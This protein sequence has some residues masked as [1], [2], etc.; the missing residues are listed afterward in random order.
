MKKHKFNIFP[1]A[2]PDDYAKILKDIKANGYDAS[3]PITTYQGDILDGWNRQ[4]ACN[5]LG[6]APIYSEFAGSDTEAV[7]FMARTNNRRT[8]ITSAQWACIAAESE[9]ILESLRTET[10]RV[11]REK[12]KANA[13]NQSD[14]PSP[15]ELG[16]G[17]ND[18]HD[19]ETA[20]KAAKMFN[21]NRE[22]ISKAVK[23]K[24]E[25]PEKFEQVKAGELS[26]YNATD[27]SKKD[28]P[29]DSESETEREP[30]VVDGIKFPLPNP[31]LSDDAKA[32]G[33]E[34]EK[35]SDKL[36][37][38][39]STWRSTNKK[40]KASFLAWVSTK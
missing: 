3:M 15:N 37:L 16:E 36:W 26:M 1:E 11:K 12:Q 14:E 30:L 5:D 40:D 35:D 2:S 28:K 9:E 17:D 23:L 27:R 34:A 24:R 39:K 19:G 21:T 8:E 6:V 18:Q 4:R 33:D 32:K 38:L 29:T 31:T 10:E 22:Y 7:L 20:T 25:S 13:S